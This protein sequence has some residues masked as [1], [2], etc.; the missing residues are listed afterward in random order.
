MSSEA[1]LRGGVIVPEDPGAH[2]II[3]LLTYQMRRRVNLAYYP[4]AYDVDLNN[5]H[6]FLIVLSL[7]DL[8]RV[9]RFYDQQQETIPLIVHIDTPEALSEIEHTRLFP[10]VD[11]LPVPQAPMG[12]TPDTTLELNLLAK[13]IQRLNGK[14]TP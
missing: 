14:A 7:A 4:H 8:Q 12:A 5:P 1:K 2:G 6:N 9:I 10:G 13:I 3:Q 11:V